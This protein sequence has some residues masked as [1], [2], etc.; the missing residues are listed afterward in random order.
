M[1]GHMEVAELLIDKGADEN[2]EDSYN[3]TPLLLATSDN[4]KDI[5]ELLI[6][7]GSDLNAQ[8]V[9][10]KT[11]LHHAAAGYDRKEIVKLLIAKAAD[12]NTKDQHDKTPLDDVEAQIWEDDSPEDKTAKKETANLIRKHGGKSGCGRFHS[13]GSNGWK[14]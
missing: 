14:R 13:R 6:A 8:D 9:Y 12:V 3:R 11:I 4:H 5:A 2:A 7:K 1:E 10:G